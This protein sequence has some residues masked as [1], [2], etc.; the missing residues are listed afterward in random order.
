[1]NKTIKIILISIGFASLSLLFTN[2]SNDETVYSCDKEINEYIKKNF[3]QCS[4]L[5]RPDWKELP[6]SLKIPVYLTFSA[7]QRRDFWI[8]KRDEL[9]QLEWTDLESEHI[10]LLYSKI[11]EIPDLFEEDYFSDE[12]SALSWNNFLVQWNTYGR[13]IL[14][15]DVA[16]LYAIS[17][18]GEEVTPEYLDKL[19]SAIG[20][21]VLKSTYGSNGS[22]G[23]CN[24]STGFWCQFLSA[25]YWD[26]VD[27]SCG[28][29]S[30]GCG[31]FL[32]QSCTGTCELIELRYKENIGDYRLL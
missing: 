24:C 12:A 4:S 30:S 10:N 3:E 27:T 14:H 31:T 20:D 15:W 2:C 11:E 5:S 32:L 23:N 17:S 16:M 25:G 6:D 8:E 13:D 21:N 1:M 18:S 29:S 7:K 9:I 28:G 19:R 26:C 22:S